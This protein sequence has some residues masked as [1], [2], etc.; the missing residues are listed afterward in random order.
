[1]ISGLVL[2]GVDAVLD[3]YDRLPNTLARPA[4]TSAFTAIL[5]GVGVPDNGVCGKPLCPRSISGV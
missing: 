1:M 3:P 2:L 4:C 5:A